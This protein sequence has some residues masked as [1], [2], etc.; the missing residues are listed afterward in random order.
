MSSSIGIA[1]FILGWG[2]IPYAIAVLAP[3]WRWLLGIT[4]VIGSLLCAGWIQHWIVSSA[5]DYREG[6]GGPI[7]IALFVLITIGF[8]TG[9]GVRALTLILAS[10]GLSLRYVF[11][12]CVA[13]AAIVPVVLWAPG[14]WQDWKM[15]APPEACL[16]AKFDIRVADAR[17]VVPNLPFLIVYL[18]RTPGRNAY[19]F[20]S[21]PSLRA[22]CALSDDGRQVVR[23]ASIW[24][25]FE[26]QGAFAPVICTEPVA[27]WAKTFCE[28]Y[29]SG[30]SS[31]KMSVDFPLDTHVFAP[32][33]ARLGSFGG[34][35]STYQ[36][37]LH[38]EVRPREVE[39]IRADIPTPDGQPL[40]FECR[41]SGSGYWCKAG[42]PWVEG[43]T[44]NYTFR[45]ARND[46]V[47]RGSRIDV[48]VRKFLSG[49]RTAP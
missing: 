32:D 10:R 31:R 36:D 23:A 33:E 37:S 13:G 9:V 42:Y 45:S 49:F 46:I 39:F 12:I 3:T 28:A 24:L 19:Y 8:F 16:N 1:A 20:Y 7:G 47:A 29:G 26:Q 27:D 25:K 48:E 22:F 17:F 18:G 11:M 35:R 2:L 43:A 41:P 30:N 38:A 15:R 40:T 34:S 6:A 4:L 5:P 44:L 21:N 14:A